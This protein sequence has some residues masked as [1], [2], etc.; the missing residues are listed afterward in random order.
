MLTEL[1]CL[2]SWTNTDAWKLTLI[3]A[4]ALFIVISIAFLIYGKIL[5]KNNQSFRAVVTGFRKMT[6]RPYDTTSCPEVE[7]DFNGSTI[8]SYYYR[9]MFPEEIDFDI[10]DTIT[11]MLNPKMPKAF[12]FEDDKTNYHPKNCIAMSAMGAVVLAVGLIL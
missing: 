11:I 3:F 6:S 9:Y 4:G 12:R 10:G 7:F 8:K 1:T 5:E 2:R